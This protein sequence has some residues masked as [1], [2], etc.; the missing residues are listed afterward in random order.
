[1]RNTIVIFLVAVLTVLSSRA[2]EIP[3]YG[4][5]LI[6]GAEA[7]PTSLD[8]HISGGSIDGLNM[9][10]IADGLI[11]YDK[12]CRIQPALATSWDI[13]EGGKVYE[14]HLRQGVKFHNG[15]GLTA[16]DVKWNMDRIL[17]PESI[18]FAAHLTNIESV[19]VVDDHTVRFTLRERRYTFL[20]ELIN[21]EFNTPIV[22]RE[23]ETVSG[24]IVHPIGT[25]PFE[26]VEF[27]PAVH[28]KL[29]RSKY[30]WIEGLPYLD[31]IIFR[32]VSDKQSRL[33]AVKS[34][35][36]DVT[37]YLESEQVEREIS[38][39]SKRVQYS[40]FAAGYPNMLSFNL[41][42]KPF[43][44]RRVRQAVAHSIS[45]QDILM[46][47]FGGFGDIIG[48]PISPLLPYYEP[49]ETYAQDYGK[50]KSLLAEAGYPNG[51]ETT[52]TTTNTYPHLVRMAQVLQA[53]L[54]LAGIRVKL[55]LA[56]F[57]ATI[58]KWT[59]GRFDM[60]T[61]GWGFNTDPHTIYNNVLV[62]GAPSEYMFGPGG[63]RNERIDRLARQA[64]LTAS[65]DERKTIYTRMA[66]IVIK[67]APWIFTVF[68]KNA[69]A[70]RSDVKGWDPPLN[71]QYAYSGGGLQYTWL[72]R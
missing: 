29:K 36:V 19:E 41:S 55:D 13:L 63:F 50:A 24:R 27:E 7:D 62:S 34:G 66:R 9:S 45:R 8:P 5:T 38:R 70:W 14:F 2:S 3:K 20:T 53:N 39:G 30:Y 69:N 49:V 37:G 72:D 56:D 65:F 31:A 6:V 71:S 43:T 48:R 12:H 46:A 64:A 32:T 47:V 10:L 21:N 40:F 18:A 16:G 1:M 4:G 44:D 61:I 54:A 42:R 33:N 52:L 67:E 15:R 51:F 17:D 57:T 22:A 23:S 35:A 11:D 58:S 25:G 28:V 26:F 60:A 59:E 68:E